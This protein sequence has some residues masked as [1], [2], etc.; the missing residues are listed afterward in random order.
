M[1]EASLDR[2]IIKE[3]VADRSEEG[4]EIHESVAVTDWENGGVACEDAS[5]E[6]ENI[7]VA[8]AYITV[9][10]TRADSEKVGRDDNDGPLDCTAVS[11]I[12]EL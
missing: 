6:N 4:D 10:D 7:S 1:R 12:E 3:G 9:C 8:V 11:V 5:E 2:V